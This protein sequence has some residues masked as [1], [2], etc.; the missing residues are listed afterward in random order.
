MRAGTSPPSDKKG[1]QGS[2]A[3]YHAIFC[4]D[5]WSDACD[6]CQ[7]GV[8][9]DFG[10]APR[11]C[12]SEM[13]SESCACKQDPACC[14]M[15]DDQCQ[16]CSQGL[17]S[18]RG[19]SLNAC[20]PEPA[21]IAVRWS[22]DDQESW[23]ALSSACATGLRQ[24]PISLPQAAGKQAPLPLRAIPSSLTLRAENTARGIVLQ[25]LQLDTGGLGQG[26]QLY[27]IHIHLGS[28]HRVQGVQYDLEVRS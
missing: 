28:E 10:C 16:Q 6:D 21:G 13:Q 11:A 14:V 27:E 2:C 7:F 22:Y 8:G 23:G 19:C 1:S 26:L 15:W 3:C 4:C 20:A 5:Y 25:P 9:N 17:G 12:P 18:T 24:S